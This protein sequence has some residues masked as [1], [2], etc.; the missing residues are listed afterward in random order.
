MVGYI[1]GR[2][3]YVGQQ[4][5]ILKSAS[6]M[7]LWKVSYRLSD[8]GAAAATCWPFSC[9]I[10][11]VIAK[12]FSGTENSCSSQYWLSGVINANVI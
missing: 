9:H 4:Y 3:Q 6:V 1:S 7:L 5:A 12:S 11:P 10:I 2:M 8:L